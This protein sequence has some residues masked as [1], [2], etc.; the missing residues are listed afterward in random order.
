[1]RMQE[2]MLERSTEIL[3]KVGV[4]QR[5]CRPLGSIHSPVRANLFLVIILFFCAI[6][7]EAPATTQ[8]TLGY[9]AACQMCAKRDSLNNC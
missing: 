7:R 1:M 2:A 5:L 3:I 6:R 8:G 4:I 9:L